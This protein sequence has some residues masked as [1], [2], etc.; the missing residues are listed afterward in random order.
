MADTLTQKAK[1][2]AVLLFALIGVAMAFLHWAGAFHGQAHV[3]A[4]VSDTQAGDPSDDVR[5]AERET[6]EIDESLPADFYGLP[7]ADSVQ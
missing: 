6:D 2:A 7:D 1:L 5:P 3:P 4:V